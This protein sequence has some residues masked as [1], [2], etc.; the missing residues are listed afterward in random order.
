MATA[1]VTGSST[2]I[3]LA[4][5]IALGRA[6]YQVYGTM[7]NPARAPR[8][9]SVAA[10]E[11]LPI[12]VLAMDV[13]NDASVRGTIADV[14]AVSGRIDVLVNNAGIAA[15][16]STEELPLAEF[17]R[18]METNY[19]GALRCMQAVLPEMRVQRSGHIICISSLGGRTCLPAYAP[20]SASKF[21]LECLS[22]SLAA[23]VKALGIRVSI[24]EPGV[25]TT[26]IFDKLRKVPTNTHYEHERRIYAMFDA[27][28]MQ[29]SPPEMVGD[30]VVE[31]V[32]SK[33]WKLRY[34]V[35]LDAEG[36]LQFRASKTDEQWVDL[37][38]IESNRDFAAAIKREIG[39]DLDLP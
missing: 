30:K 13:D 39:M 28:L 36:L 14:M 31:I 15:F 35:G 21:A 24:V 4:T 8:L 3:G 12:K 17:R 23:E 38:G 1:L 20:Y 37:V 5:A 33:D 29:A 11:S 32:K 27:M 26:P 10:K 9:E 18:V 7:R 6:G 22:E 34:P 2:G 19:F 16:G 25:I